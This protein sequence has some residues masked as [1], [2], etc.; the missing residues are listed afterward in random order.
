MTNFEGDIVE[1]KRKTNYAMEIS[2]D[3]DMFKNWSVSIKNVDEHI[4]SKTRRAYAYDPGSLHKQCNSNFD[5]D[6]A[7][8]LSLRGEIYKM[9]ASIGSCNVPSEECDIFQS[10]SVTTITNLEYNIEGILGLGHIQ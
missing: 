5:K 7:N 4:D 2:D 10:P 6:F 3:Y 9:S 1:D 8:A